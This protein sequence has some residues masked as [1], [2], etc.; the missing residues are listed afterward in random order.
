MKKKKDISK[1]LKMY[2]LLWQRSL[3][4]SVS[5]TL[6]LENIRFSF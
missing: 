4:I 2:S 3:F 1:F 5:M 6:L